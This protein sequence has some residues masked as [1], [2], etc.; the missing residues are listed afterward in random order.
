MVQSKL[1]KHEQEEVAVPAKSP[2]GSLG[3]KE[4]VLSRLVEQS[5]DDFLA[6]PPSDDTGLLKINQIGR[7]HAKDCTSNYIQVCMNG[8]IFTDLHY[9]GP[10]S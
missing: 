8:G 4:K 5:D 1:L 9:V 2:S 7:Y 3:T 10:G 6:L